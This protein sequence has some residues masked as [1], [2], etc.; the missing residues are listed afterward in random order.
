MGN[1][2]FCKIVRKEIPSEIVYEDDEMIAFKDIHPAAPMHLL[3][4]PKQHI[5]TL[6]D[7][8]DEHAGLLG[9]MMTRAPKLA[10]ANNCA[11]KKNE[12]GSY[13]GGFHTRI[14]CGPSGH[15][16]IYHLHIHVMGTP[17]D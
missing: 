17:S 4:I 6:S 12:D 7:C 2:I 15:Q 9:R 10:E 14:H 11:A 1:C 8:T 13:R 3:L 16:E 5:P